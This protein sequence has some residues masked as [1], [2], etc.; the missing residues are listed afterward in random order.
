MFIQETVHNRDVQKWDYCSS[1]DPP[2]AYL[3]IP[4]K[5]RWKSQIFLYFLPI[6][7]LTWIQLFCEKSTVKST[8]K[9]LNN[10]DAVAMVPLL[11]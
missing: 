9:Q 3:N 7:F 10:P 2:N 5:L 1:I 4:V 11:L 6:F 8:V